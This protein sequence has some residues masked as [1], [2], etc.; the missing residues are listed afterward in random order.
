MLILFLGCEK[1][2][3]LKKPK[4]LKSVDWENYNDAY[5]LYWKFMK[6][7]SEISKFEKKVIKIA[8]WKKWSSKN[9]NGFYLCDDPKYCDSIFHSNPPVTINIVCLFSIQ[10]L[11]DS[12]DLT[13]KCFITGTLMFNR[14]KMGMCCR[15]EPEVLVT[16][17]NDI[18]FE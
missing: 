8:G 2:C 13:K 1:T 17:I 18:Y 5:T 4:N 12:C 7:C 9:S 10:P 14:L 3:L 11:L 16:D 15:A 6:Q